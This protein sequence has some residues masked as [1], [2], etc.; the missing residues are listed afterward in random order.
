MFG[1]LNENAKLLKD[2]VPETYQKIK[3]FVEQSWKDDHEMMIYGI[4]EQADA[5][6]KIADYTKAKDYDRKIMAIA[7]SNWV[8]KINGKDYYDYELVLFTYEKQLKAKNQY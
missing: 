1:Q 7:Y 3:T 2:K 4:N 8:K 6:F 5:M